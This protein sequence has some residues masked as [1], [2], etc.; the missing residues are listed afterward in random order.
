MIPNTLIELIID[1]SEVGLDC[2]LDDGL[3]KE[4]PTIK[5]L[6]SL[7]SVKITISDKILYKK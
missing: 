6:I 2:I 1:N 3:L 7:Y 5:D 4:I